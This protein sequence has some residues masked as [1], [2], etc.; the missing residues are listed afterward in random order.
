MP[1][2]L[3]ILL[4]VFSTTLSAQESINTSWS[5]LTAWDEQLFPKIKAH[6]QYTIERDES[7]IPVIKAVSTQS[8]SGL[9][10]KQLVNVY[11]QPLISW[12]WNVSNVFSKGDATKKSGDDYPARVYILFEYDPERA[13][14]FK[15]LRYDSVKLIYGLYPP[16]TT[17][18]Y[19]WANKTHERKY[20]PN[21]YSAETMMY[22][23]QTGVH[24]VGS[25]QK[26]SRH[27][28]NDYRASFEQDPPTHAR[29]GIMVDSDNTRE[30][31][32][33]YFRN[34]KIARESRS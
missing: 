33:T 5:D 19:I 23:L 12:E 24:N 6:T 22:I 11:Q 18:N 34:F 17:L 13:S 26:E 30:S 32:T 15:R 7:D 21:P 27:I 31:A 3:S 10:H 9:I 2:V 25:W 1:L 14:V 20:I 29:I 28:L 16:D 4:I 8:A